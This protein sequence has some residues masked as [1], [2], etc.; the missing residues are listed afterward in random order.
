M[1]TQAL[2]V[3]EK[4]GFVKTPGGMHSLRSVITPEGMHYF[5]SIDN[6]LYTKD[7]DSI[8]ALA[9][10][11]VSVFAGIGLNDA[12]VVHFARRQN[13]LWGI[14]SDVTYILIAGQELI[15]MGTAAELEPD[16]LYLLTISSQ[17]T[18]G[19]S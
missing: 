8:A 3:G 14:S 11:S 7:I 1:I 10:F 12:P 5:Y 2:Y 6:P 17:D 4:L 18:G 13:Q 9:T 19:Q 15:E 16:R